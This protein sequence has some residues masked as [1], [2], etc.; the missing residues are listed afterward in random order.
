MPDAFPQKS[1]SF[2][3][4]KV[5]ERIEQFQSDYPWVF[6]T[7]YYISFILVAF[8]CAF[9]FSIYLNPNHTD[10][11]SARLLLSALIQSEATIIALVITLTLVAVQLTSSS[12]TPRVAKIFA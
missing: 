11:N 7:S 6:W 2:H 10:V 4:P 1:S 12:F 9:V 8:L 3:L 5:T